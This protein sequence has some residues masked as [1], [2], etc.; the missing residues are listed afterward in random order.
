MKQASPEKL[1]ESADQWSKLQDI[2]TWYLKLKTPIDW[3]DPGSEASLDTDDSVFWLA[4]NKQKQR[5][6]SV[7]A[8][9]LTKE[10]E[11]NL[12][13][14]EMFFYGLERRLFIKIYTN[15]GLVESIELTTPSDT[16]QNWE[17]YKT[18]SNMAT[19]P[20]LMHPDKEV[21]Q[22]YTTSLSQTF[23]AMLIE[24]GRQTHS[25]YKNNYISRGDAL[26]N[27]VFEIISTHMHEKLTL[28]SVANS[29]NT[30]ERTVSRLFKL[31]SGFSF[32]KQLVVSRVTRAQNYLIDG[33][34]G[35]EEIGKSLG[36]SNRHHF[37]RSFKELFGK[38]PLQYQ[39]LWKKVSSE[40]EGLEQLACPNL[41]S[42][43]FH[44]I[45]TDKGSEPESAGNYHALY[46][47][48]ATLAP[49]NVEW[50]TPSG[51]GV[52][53]R[54]LAP[55]KIL[56]INREGDHGEWRISNAKGKVFKAFTSLAEDCQ[57]I[58]GR[59]PDE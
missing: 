50:L 24:L 20:L 17:L 31:Y 53:I 15:V 51:E 48:N 42:V 56:L 57:A 32:S 18:W 12:Y 33:Y 40:R 30:S 36:F 49:C 8:G 3:V 5:L 29:L 43:N 45:H 21:A 55:G 22:I 46:I 39:K 25:R 44:S 4:L 35:V 52:F 2:L 7:S 26:I 9:H 6:C 58:I 28:S 41:P 1:T 37:I 11:P 16:T 14:L 59:T 47:F 27:R 23:L 10:P 34:N 54:S 13:P 19:S 38:T